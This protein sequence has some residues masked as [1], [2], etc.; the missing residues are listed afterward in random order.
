VY[1]RDAL[2]E[3][4]PESFALSSLSSGVHCLKLLEDWETT[5]I[6]ENCFDILGMSAKQFVESPS[7]WIGRVHPADIDAIRGALQSTTESIEKHISYRFRD[8]KERYRWIGLRCK[9]LNAESVV[10]VFQEITRQRIVEYSDRIHFAGRNS[11]RALLDSSNLTIAVDSFL[12]LIGNALI[13]DR[14]RLM[15]FRKDGNAFITHEWVRSDGT[16]TL[17]LPTKIKPEAADWW[18]GQFESLGVV[19]I[20]DT[21]NVDVPKAVQAAIRKHAVG[22]VMAAPAIING[23]VEGFICIESFKGRTWLPLELEE[24]KHIVDGYSRSVERR[25]E[26]RKQIAEELNL[27][28]SEERYRL[29]T[30]HSPVILFGIDSEGIFTLSEGLGLERMGAGAGDVVGASVYQIYRN[31]PE[32]LEQVNKALTGVESHGLFH[33]GDNCFEM[34]LT[35]VSDEDRVVVGISG[36]AVDVT[37]RNKLEQQKTIMMSELD[38]R[39]KNNIAAVISLVGLSKEGAHSI[40]DFAKTLDGRLHALAV[41]HSTLAKS[42]WS[43]AW[44]RDILLLTLQPYMVGET[45]RIK[46]VGPDV[47]LLGMLARPMCMVIHE[48]ATNAVKHGALSISGGSVLITTELPPQKNSIKVTWMEKGG[49]AIVEEIKPGTGTSLLEGLVGYEMD[50]VISMNY[51]TDGLVCQIEVSIDSKN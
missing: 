33:I 19:S 11:L 40:E 10:G 21:G 9:R 16:E 2:T 1:R 46:F 32:I 38:H 27:R 15:R 23:V 8:S 20:P 29:L 24:V 25:I 34:W 39:V 28:T 49:P 30:T 36:V 12:G 51:T 26:D 4:T 6:S 37:R 14:A 47:E 41:A 31:Y 3:Q 22:A 7:H 50:G 17:E 13:V 18:Q 42:H 45:E 43:G 35:P 44:M 5:Y 48:L